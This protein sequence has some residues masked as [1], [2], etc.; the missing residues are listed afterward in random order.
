MKS[1]EVFF[2]I[3][4]RR[5]GEKGIKGVAN[6]SHSKYSVASSKAVVSC[7]LLAYPPQMSPAGAFTPSRAP[8]CRMDPV[9]V[10]PKVCR[11]KG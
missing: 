11:M 7:S 2:W 3:K 9:S 4:V 8:N 5:N 10:R 6:L 1:G